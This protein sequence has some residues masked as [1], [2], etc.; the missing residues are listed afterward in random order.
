MPKPVRRKWAAV[1]DSAFEPYPLVAPP[2]KKPDRVPRVWSNTRRRRRRRPLTKEELGNREPKVGIRPGLVVRTKDEKEKDIKPSEPSESV[3]PF[4][5]L[6]HEHYVVSGSLGITAKVQTPMPV[7]IDTGAGY[8]VIRKAALPPGWEECVTSRRS[9]PPLGDAGGHA[10]KISREVLLRVRFGNALYRVS[11]LVAETLAVPVVLGTQFMNRH[12]DAIRCIAGRIDFTGDTLPIIGRGDRDKPWN[13]SNARIVERVTLANGQKAKLGDESSKLTHIRLARAVHLPPYTQCKAHALTLLEG[14]IV[15]EPKHSVVERYGVRVMNSVHEVT[16]DRPFPILMSNFTSKERVLPKG[17]VVAYA[18]RSPVGLVSLDGEQSRELASTFGIDESVAQ[19]ERN[20]DPFM[21]LTVPQAVFAMVDHALERDKPTHEYAPSIMLTA[22]AE[23][24]DTS[25]PTQGDGNRADVQEITPEPV[26]DMPR[27][28]D[29][30][31]DA[32]KARPDVDKNWR[33][34][35]KLDHVEDTEFRDRIM[36]MLEKHETVFE[37]KLGQVESTVH[38]INLKPGTPPVRLQPYRAGPDKRE[39]IREQIEYQLA[40][41]VIEPA[42]TEWSS[43]VLLAPKKDG[44]QR[45][46]VDFRRLN[47]ATIP[48]TYPL[49]RMD[50]CIDSLSNANIFTLLDALWGYWQVPIAEED[51]DKTTF[52]SHMGT[53]RYLRMPFGL[54]NAPSTFQRALDIALSGVRWRICLVYIDDVIVFSQNREEHLEHL[55]T[56]LSLLKE[57][58]IKLKLKKCFFFKDEVEYL[59][60]RIRPGTLS[61]YPDAKAIAAVQNATFPQT[62]TQMKSFLGACNVYRKFIRGLA[63]KS[64]PLTDMLKKDSGVDWHSPIEPD[65]AQL[66]AFNAL[67][68][69]LIKPPILAL[70]KKGRPYMIDCDASA[71]AIGVVLLQQQD[72]DKPTEWATV[73]YY[74][75]TL[76]KEQR[77]YSATERECYAV[78]WGVLTLRPYLEGTEFMVRTD[79]N[80]LKWMLTLNDPTGRLMR[81][82]LRLMEFS[83]EIIYRPGRKHQ[84]PD[85]LSRV[86]RAPDSDDDDEVDE[87]IP[88]FVDRVELVNVLVNVVTRRQAL[89]GNYKKAMPVEPVTYD[90]AEPSEPKSST[91]AKPKSVTKDKP[92]V[93]PLVR[94]AKVNR[95]KDYTWK[96]A[97]HLPLP[98]EDPDP[99]LDVYDLIADARDAI[100]DG[101]L[102]GEG[103][104]HRAN[105]GADEQP[106]PSPLTIEEILEEQRKDEYCTSLFTTQV[107]RKT[108]I[109]FE[110]EDGVLCRRNPREQD[111]I[112]IVLPSSLRH[113]VL[114]MA[115]Y[116]PLAGHPGQTRLQQRLRRTYYWPQMT[117]DA[118]TTVRECES[119]AKNRIRLLKQSGAMRLF[120]ALRPLEEIAVDILGPLPKSTEGHRFIFVI[121]DRFS[122]LTQA[123]P[124][125][126]IKAIDVSVAL[127][128]HW[129]FKYGPPK[130]LLS[131]NGSQFISDI[132]HR[133]CNLLHVR[134]ALTMTYHPQTNGQ[135][136]RFNRSLTAMLRCY[137]EDHPADWSQY[138]G[139]VT[140][141]YNCAVHRTTGNTPF[142][143][144]LSRSPPDFTLSYKSNRKYAKDDKFD[145]KDYV[146]RLRVAV[147]RANESLRKNQRKYKRDF[148]KRVRKT[149]PLTDEDTVY[150]DITDGAKKRDKLSH[151][152]GGAYEVL[153]VSPVTK[154]VVIQRGNVVERVSMNR[155]T[156]APRTAKVI[157]PDTPH[158]LSATPADLAEK[159]TEGRSYYFKSILDHR[160]LD[161][162]SVEF[163]LDWEGYKPTWTPRRDVPEESISRYFA[164][165]ANSRRNSLPGPRTNVLAQAHN[166]PP[167]VCGPR[168]GVLRRAFNPPPPVVG[169]RTQVRARAPNPPPLDWVPPVSSCPPLRRAPNPPPLDFVL[170]TRHDDDHW[171]DVPD[172]VD[173][174]PDWYDTPGGNE[175]GNEY[176]YF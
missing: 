144:V 7:V 67:K 96:D 72:P 162:G 6:A 70:P 103:D 89:S 36:R 136:E 86:P 39:K 114:R 81:W 5:L 14:L 77:N 172:L 124:L 27:M 126:S 151:G 71:Y 91:V 131:D 42:N 76:T 56:V 110:N 157:G 123:I 13:E 50:D 92:V 145:R 116:H 2:M 64:T 28:E 61:A 127:V 23:P 163:K 125:P 111:L 40:A 25:E 19:S 22:S 87:E 121:V 68:E 69:A 93:K 3:S 26:P 55:D 167:P 113:R 52:T 97:S 155:V 122:K 66:E 106:L 29:V 79:H 102:N 118:A 135:T 156:R 43:P 90:A 108:S 101:R 53:Y 48:D 120:Q 41:G 171:N 133:V 132:F 65:D 140:Y 141:A 38:R 128:N 8:N 37:G 82:R 170:P 63:H 161:D 139:A 12:I 104:P 11:F 21:D 54:R 24:G 99:E 164:R 107:G 169:P 1:N 138:V 168:V 32:P 150:L 166:P 152:V 176:G 45:F 34:Q 149:M 35:I 74:S 4:L 129:I 44:T 119:C 146:H 17:M 78:V 109:F 112:Q 153:E 159:S 18:S 154:T 147:K 115:H 31:D 47:A 46:C 58:G 134:N 49:P 9:F 62:P 10:L 20:Q 98:D 84:V 137:V 73:G 165:L 30:D 88:T 15:T 59:G 83:Y 33:D 105:Q 75:K 16:S 175:C 94:D 142:D 117:A 95:R 85:A 158:A 174:S 173:E 57:A 51:K 143:L 148:D 100:L 60:F 80:A 130:V 160:T